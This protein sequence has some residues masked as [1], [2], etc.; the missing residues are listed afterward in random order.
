MLDAVK[1]FA[2]KY[3]QRNS[4]VSAHPEEMPWFL[5]QQK[6]HKG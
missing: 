6:S 3:I 2:T 4:N 1:L 5:I